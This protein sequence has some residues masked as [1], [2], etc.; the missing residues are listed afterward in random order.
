M[1]INV[2]DLLLHKYLNSEPKTVLV[3]DQTGG[4]SESGILHLDLKISAKLL[5]I[6]PDICVMICTSTAAA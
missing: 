1:V 4:V 2:G 5:V 6:I 3:D